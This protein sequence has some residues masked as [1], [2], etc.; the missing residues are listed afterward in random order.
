VFAVCIL[1]S[2]G[3]TATFPMSLSLIAT[4]ANSQEQTTALSAFSQGWGYLIAGL[5]TFAFG[6]IAAALQSW[7]AVVFGIVVL[8]VLQTAIGIYAG[9]DAKVAR[10]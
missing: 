8:T 2:V 6:S 7:A 4:R 3:Q 10:Q 1:I 5:G 9:R